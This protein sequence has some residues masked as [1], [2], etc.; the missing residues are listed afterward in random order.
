MEC[1]DSVRRLI[2]NADDF[3]RSHS[4]NQAVIRAHRE[5]ILTSASLMVNE[6]GFDEAVKVA[7]EN[8]KL[9]V[10][11]HL[12]LLQGHSTLPP[13]K[14]PGLVNS[15]GEFSESPAGVGLDYFFKRNLREQLRAETRA[16]FEKFHSTGL[17]LDHVNGHLHLHLHPAVF[18]ILMEDSEKL[19]IR[20]FRLTRDCLS[21]SRRMSRGHW[22]YRVSHAAIFEILSRRARKT[23][24][25]KKIRHAQIT[26]GLLQN[27]RVNED[28][29]LKLL[30]EL[31]PGDSELYSHPSLDE[32][33]HEFDALV[34]PRV[35]ELAKKLGIELI[36]YQ[37]L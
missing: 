21:R 8:P 19:G 13:E 36:R 26:F 33:K 17:L 15:L 32:F 31:P 3:G 27:A 16:Q 10:G 12:T 22:F 30:P 25:Q 24:E 7:K 34:S 6:N 20:N 23:L 1:L 35:K 37:D 14:I 4:I 2:V 18:R 5:G 29:I 11:L 28:Y 9:G